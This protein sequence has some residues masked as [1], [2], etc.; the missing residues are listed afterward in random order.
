MRALIFDS[1]LKYASLHSLPPRKSGE[2]LIK[3][4]LAGICRTDMEIIQGYQNFKGILGHEFVGVVQ[5][6][7]HK[8][9]IG[10]R[11]VGEINIGCHECIPCKRGMKEHCVRR[12]VIG[13]HGKDGCF[14]DYV[15]LPE[16]NLHVL[17]DEIT[18]E[19]AIFV[20]PLAAAYN[21]LLGVP[22]KPTDS[23]LII[24]DGKLGVL[25]SQVIKL[26]GA[27]LYCL[28]KHRKKLSIMEW[29]GIETRLLCR[30]DDSS[31][32]AANNQ[33]VEEDISTRKFDVVIEACGSSGGLDMARRLVMPKGSL[34][35]KS[36]LHGGALIDLTFAVLN[37]VKIVGS[38]CGPFEPAI[39]AIRRQLV[40][41]RPLLS[42]RFPLEEWKNAFEQARNPDAYKVIFEINQK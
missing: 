24:G 5:D 17:P 32:I 33:G 2:A 22:I 28:G 37:E 10:K 29:M 4:L 40:E 34:V 11:V 13:I 9:L 42:G 36:T 39:R 30:V 14:A 12:K 23:V 18:N 16:D 26:T 31:I 25:I 15:A 35:L 19:K 38:R 27:D 3:V 1:E 21:V 41:V 8:N 6:A 20:E 7:A